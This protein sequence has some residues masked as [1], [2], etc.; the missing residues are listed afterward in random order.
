MVQCSAIPPLKLVFMN[1]HSS[2]FENKNIALAFVMRAY[3]CRNNISN[4][5]ILYLPER[6]PVSHRIHACFQLAAADTGCWLFMSVISVHDF[7]YPFREDSVYFDESEERSKFVR[8][9]AEHCCRLNIVMLNKT[10]TSYDDRTNVQHRPVSCLHVHFAITS[11]SWKPNVC[12][13]ILSSPVC[14]FFFFGNTIL[15]A[16]STPRSQ[17]PCCVRTS[18]FLLLAAFSGSHE[19][20]TIP[21][22]CDRVLALST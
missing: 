22:C 18:L 4:S 8:V 14:V 19:E 11:T 20:P 6:R 21:N 3:A 17:T 9:E 10:R 1:F 7:F 13:V 5:Y 2:N 16:G 12:P 15:C